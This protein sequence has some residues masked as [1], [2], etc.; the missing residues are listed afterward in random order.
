MYDF[1]SVLP[2]DMLLRY[3]RE[4]QAE[5]RDQ[6]ARERLLPSSL[7]RGQMARFLSGLRPQSCV[8]WMSRG[9]LWAVSRHGVRRLPG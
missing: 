4:R 7:T 2:P 9:R 3:V 5:I 1:L 8:S 6:C